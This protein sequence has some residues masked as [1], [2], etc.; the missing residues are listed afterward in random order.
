MNRRAAGSAADRVIVFAACFDRAVCLAFAHAAGIA[1][2]FAVDFVAAL[3][4]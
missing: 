4:P 2:L 1:T 3:E